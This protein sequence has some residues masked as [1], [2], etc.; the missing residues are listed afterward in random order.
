MI[1]IRKEIAEV[2]DG[3]QPREGN[4]LKHAPH[5]AEVVTAGRWDIARTPGSSRPS[6]RRSWP[7]EQVL[8]G[9]GPAQQRAR[10]PEAH[11]QL[12]A[13]EDYLSRGPAVASDRTGERERSADRCGREKFRS[14]RARLGQTTRHFTADRGQS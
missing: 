5:T 7:G 2:E 13:V 12:P 8:A 9:G 3:R 4:V 1:A 6:R 10:R 11:L 14:A